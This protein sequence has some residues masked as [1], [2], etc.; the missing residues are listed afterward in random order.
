M[1]IN[2]CNGSNLPTQLAS[3]V[4]LNTVSH[5]IYLHQCSADIQE[6]NVSSTDSDVLAVLGLIMYKR[7][8]EA[9]NL[10]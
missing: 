3:T 1:M 4:K 6:C 2:H 10:K 5:G 7:N 9:N 8:L